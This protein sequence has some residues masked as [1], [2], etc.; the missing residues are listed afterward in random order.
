[1]EQDGIGRPSTYAPILSTIQDRNYIE[2]DENKKFRP[3]EIGIVVNDLLVSHFPEIVDIKFTAKMEEELDEIAEGKKKWVPVIREFYEPFEENLK[4]KE[5]EVSKKDIAE[6]TNRKN[7][8][9]MRSSAFN[10]TGQIWQI[11]CLFKISQM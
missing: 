10:Q 7:L 1:M 6:E 3:T 8:P 4:K 5:K 11:L 2:K 9:Q